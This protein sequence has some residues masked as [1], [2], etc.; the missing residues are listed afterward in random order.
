MGWPR[1]SSAK[2]AAR[3]ASTGGGSSR[4]RVTVPLPAG[5]LRACDRP[6]AALEADGDPAAAAGR[7]R[8]ERLTELVMGSTAVNGLHPTG[9]PG[10]RQV[11]SV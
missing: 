10:S 11:N 1:P 2:A 7:E 8:L 5:P 3:L 9:D 6:A 4:D